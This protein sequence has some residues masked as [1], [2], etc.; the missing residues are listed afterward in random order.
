ML[1]MTLDNEPAGICSRKGVDG[2]SFRCRYLVTVSL[3]GIDQ[4]SIPVD[5]VLP[6]RFDDTR[7]EA[8]PATHQRWWFRPYILTWSV[9]REDQRYA[10]RTDPYAAEGLARWKAEGRASWLK[11]FPSGESFSVRCLDGGAWDRSTFWG[12]FDNLADA[13]ACTFEGPT[14]RRRAG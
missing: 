2:R 12:S 3:C 1:L 13:V 9:E 14:W 5:P 4:R 10:E 11:A 8:R 7:N 6:R